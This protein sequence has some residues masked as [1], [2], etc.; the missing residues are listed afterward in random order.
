MIP[1]REMKGVRGT[2]PVEGSETWRV[3]DC[4]CLGVLKNNP[5]RMKHE[6][7]NEYCSREKLYSGV[8]E[9]NNNGLKINGLGKKGGEFSNDVSEKPLL[10]CSIHLEPP[11]TWIV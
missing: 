4:V 7:Q 8:E 9:K 11:A 6:E 1:N 2:K 3:G 5:E 10:C